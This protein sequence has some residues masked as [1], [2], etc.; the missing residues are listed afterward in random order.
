MNVLYL[1]QFVTH[2]LRYAVSGAMFNVRSNNFTV[3]RDLFLRALNYLVSNYRSFLNQFRVA[4]MFLY[5]L[6]VLR[7]LSKR[8]A[9]K[10]ALTSKVVYLRVFLSVLSTILCL[11]S[12]IS[13]SVTVIDI[14]VF[15]TFMRFSSNLRRL[16]RTSAVNR[17]NEGRQSARRLTRFIMISIVSALLNFVGRIR[18]TRR[19]SIRICRLNNRVRITLRI[20]NVSSVSRS[21]Q[22]VLSRLL[23]RVGLFQEVNEGEVNTQRVCRIR[24]VTIM[25]DFTRLN[26]RNC[27]TVITRAF[28]DAQYRIRR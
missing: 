5:I 25:F 12:I 11:V 23:T 1:A 15:L 9:N 22:H 3:F 2:F 18:N 17:S 21:V 24:V 19:T 7:R 26:V 28:I 20:T 27:S 10:M 8:M 6:V 13:I 4:G 16:V 14:K